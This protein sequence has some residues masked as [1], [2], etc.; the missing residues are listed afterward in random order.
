MGVWGKAFFVEVGRLSGFG[1]TKGFP[2][3]V[4]FHHQPWFAPL[5]ARRL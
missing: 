3:A 2:V 4:A 1:L 5:N